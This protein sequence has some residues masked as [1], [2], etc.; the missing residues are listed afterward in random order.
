LL[1]L[2]IIVIIFCS[3]DAFYDLA[4]HLLTL[5][6]DVAPLLRPML[7]RFGELCNLCWKKI[8]PSVLR[9]GIQKNAN[10]YLSLVAFF[11]RMPDTSSCLDQQVAPSGFTLRQLFLL[12][13]RTILKHSGDYPDGSY[14]QIPHSEYSFEHRLLCALWLILEINV[15]D[16]TQKFGG[17][18]ENILTPLGEAFYEECAYCKKKGETEKVM[19]RCQGC[20]LVYYCDKKC[21]KEHWPEH[22]NDCQVWATQVK[23]EGRRHK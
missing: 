11:F 21:Y 2:L 15:S 13:A 19:K 16:I 8:F 5:K 9:D 1:L 4:I 23:W 7:D 20:T 18:T 6:P 3:V 12:S 10:D 22:K 17:S 14:P